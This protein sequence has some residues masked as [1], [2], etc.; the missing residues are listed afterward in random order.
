MLIFC[1]YFKPQKEQVYDQ[2]NF[3]LGY[4]KIFQQYPY[5]KMNILSIDVALMILT[6]NLDDLNNEQKQSLKQKFYPLIVS[7]FRSCMR[8]E[9]I[10]KVK[11]QE[12]INMAKKKLLI[13]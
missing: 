4:L 2:K 11:D 3:F 10:K 6:T 8:P 12:D 13:Q 1:K 9:L 7:E 5:Y